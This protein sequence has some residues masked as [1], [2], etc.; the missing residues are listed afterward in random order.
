MIED[1][2]RSRLTP[3][4]IARL[5]STGL[6]TRPLR[7]VLAALGIAIG[8]AAMVAI[9]GISSSSSAEITLRIDDLGPNLLQVSGAALLEGQGVAKLPRTTQAAI[10]RIGPVISAAETGSLPIDVYRNSHVPSGETGSVEVLAADQSL[11]STLHATLAI[12]N[13]F[14]AASAHFPSV[15]LGAQAAEHLGVDRLGTDVVVG[16]QL[17][18]VVGVLNPVPLAPELDASA[19]VGWQAAS[20]YF[21]FSGRPT[22]V[23]VRVVQSQLGAVDS[24]VPRSVSPT[25]PNGVAVVVPSDAIAARE[26]A[27][28]TLSGLLIGLAGVAL[29]VGGI[30]IANTMVVSVL[31]RRGEIGLRRA[32]GATRG[33]VRVQ[34]VGEAVLLSL[35]GGVAGAVSGT[36]VTAAYST[37]R[38]WPVVVPVWVSLAGVAVTAV[39]GG[40][41]GLYPAIRASRTSPTTALASL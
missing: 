21:Q 5:G 40:L 3:A 15:V 20:T 14:T 30:G 26:A 9:V 36:L 37:V 28:S 27:T 24:I 16:G 39:I 29:I 1:L 2:Q 10:A 18:A 23:Y 35:L 22:N 34:F 38:G 11:L 12:G 8:V 31:E 4:D 6:R 13:W 17:A 41:S 32:L 19:L 25:A 7:T 33:Q